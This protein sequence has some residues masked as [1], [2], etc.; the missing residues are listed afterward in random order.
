MTIDVQPIVDWL[1]A[2]RGPAT[3]ADV[4]ARF[5][6]DLEARG[7]RVARIAAFVLSLHPEILGRRFVWKRGVSGAGVSSAPFTVARTVGYVESPVGQILEKRCEL[8]WRLEG[9][10]PLAYPPLEEQRA[11]GMTD[12]LALPMHFLNGQVHAITYC[13]DAAGGFSDAELAAIRRATVP[14]A[15]VAE[16]LA[17]TRSAANVLDAYVGHHAGTRILAGQVRR[18]ET[19]R[20]HCVIWFSDLRGF[21]VL[22]GTQDPEQT[23]AVLNRLFDCQVP[24]VEKH[25]GEVL[26]FIGDGMLAI[27]RVTEASPVATVVNEALAAAKEAFA[28]L[29]V[30]NAERLAASA[31]PF[32]FGLA[33]HVGEVAYGNIGSAS[34]LDFTCIG[35]AV[36]LAARVEGL[37]SKLGKRLLLTD[38]VAG[39]VTARTRSLGAHEVKGVEPAPVVHELADV[40]SLPPPA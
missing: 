10:A 23:I 12:Y 40:W 22:S 25:G 24:A 39:L 2:M 16:I 34:R 8:R 32:Q 17:V 14:L 20:I 29:D 33:L 1:L 35:A 19:E 6:Q 13:T 15:R 26:K 4:L 3:S 9:S 5:G 21:T 30:W 28:A 31:K 7:V 38:A 37:A 18:G 27:F 36:N 11:E